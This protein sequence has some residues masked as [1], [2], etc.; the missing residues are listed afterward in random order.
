MDGALDVR[1]D[2]VDTGD[3]HTVE[4]EIVGRESVVGNDNVRIF[5]GWLDVFLEGW[6]GFGLVSLEKVGE[7]HLL[8]C[9][10]LCIF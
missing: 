3:R 1:G 2:D 5:L 8:V 9:T 4:L 10:H 6:L 7:R